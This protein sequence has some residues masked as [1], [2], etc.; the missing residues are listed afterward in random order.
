MR[1]IHNIEKSAFHKGEYVGYSDGVWRIVKH[2]R[3]WRAVHTKGI[4]WSQEA[5][6]LAELSAKI[7]E[8]SPYQRIQPK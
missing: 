5:R 8:C 2:S 3:V 7:D 1:Y 4:H 6:T